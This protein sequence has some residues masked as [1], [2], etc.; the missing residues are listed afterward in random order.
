MKLMVLA[1]EGEAPA[2]PTGAAAAFVHDTAPDMRVRD[3]RTNQGQLGFAG[4]VLL[5]GLAEELKK[6]EQKDGGQKGGRK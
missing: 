4:A 2:V 3:W 1:F 6:R 5:V